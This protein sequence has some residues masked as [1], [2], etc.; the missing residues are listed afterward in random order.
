MAN[1]RPEKVHA[2]DRDSGARAEFLRGDRE[3]IASDFLLVRC[4]SGIAEARVIG[5][6]AVYSR[7]VHLSPLHTEAAT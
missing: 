3:V 6:S 2:R 5:K 1:G 4:Y 7:G